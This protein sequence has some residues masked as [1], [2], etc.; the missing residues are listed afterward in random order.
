MKVSMEGIVKSFGANDVLR[1]VDFT[2]QGGS[3]SAS[4]AEKIIACQKAAIKAKAPI[5]ALM[6]SGGAKIQ[7]GIEALKQVL[8]DVAAKGLH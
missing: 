8:S 6:D 7:E 1:Q 3:L 4:N 5:I 2:V